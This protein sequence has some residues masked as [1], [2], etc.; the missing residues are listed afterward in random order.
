MTDRLLSVLVGPT[1]PACASDDLRWRAPFGALWHGQCRDCGT[2]YHWY[3]A[4]LDDA[5][6]PVE[7]TCPGCAMP[8][9]EEETG[10]VFCEDCGPSECAYCGGTTLRWKLSENL[11]CETCEHGE[12]VA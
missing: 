2:E 3:A 7:P 10:A 6:A 11:A 12:A 9:D 8:H 1:C 4:P 5:G